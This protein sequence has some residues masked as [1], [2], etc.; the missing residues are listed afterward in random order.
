MLSRPTYRSIRTAGR[1]GVRFFPE[2]RA[3][4][5]VCYYGYV[6]NLQI[7]TLHFLPWCRLDRE[8]RARTVALIPFS[9]EPPSNLDADIIRAVRTIL[10]D[11]IEVD[12]RTV[13]R[14]TL[15]SLEGRVFI[16]GFRNDRSE[17]E[18]IE[19]HVQIACLS[20]LEG[21]EYL[22]AAEPYSNSECFGLYARQY[23][24]GA[25]AASPIFRRD[26]TP[27]G[28]AGA[29]LRVHMPVQTVSVPRISLNE[30]LYQSLA[31]L[32]RRLLEK[33]RVEDWAVWAES[34][35][36]FNLANTDSESASA[37]MEWVLMSSAIERLLCAR[38]SAP[39]VAEK[40]VAALIP[41]E[42]R[43]RA[44]EV[45][46]DWAKEFYRLRNDFAH[47]KCEAGSHAHGIRRHTCSSAQLYSRCWSR[48][49]WSARES[50]GRPKTTAAKCPRSRAS[51]RNCATPTQSS[52]LGII[53]C[54]IGGAHLT[55]QGT[56][57]RS[58]LPIRF[59]NP[60]LT[61]MQSRAGLCAALRIVVKL[62]YCVQHFCRL[63][64]QSA[65]E[66]VRV[67]AGRTV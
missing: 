52:S 17:F 37:H 2:R 66:S 62:S 22:G 61:M 5:A 7:P 15:V 47:G 18:T 50:I 64:G 28:L 39:D 59:D 33:E 12:R 23:R 40:V 55:R 3:L 54:A 56:N 43:D 11:F 44:L 4:P 58:H 67:S 32:R 45:V 6:S 9:D 19:D 16:E 24:E 26:S 63:R 65:R 13:T 1:A 10:A 48:G 20:A 41:Q 38:P 49:F 60:V 8:Y 21:R 34:I 29:A 57:H 46:H 42:T 36:S 30:A 53:M 31:D 35:Y 14:C 51:P 27:M 25:A